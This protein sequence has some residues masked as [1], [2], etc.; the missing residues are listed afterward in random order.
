VILAAIVV[1]SAVYV[2]RLG[3]YAD[4]WAFAEM[5]QGS[6]DKSFAGLYAALASH[7]NLAVRPG[8]IVW[9]ILLHYL[10]PDD[11]TPA[12]V[13]NHAVFA[14]SAVLLYA[15]LR[16]LR[17]ARGAAYYVTLLYVCL[18]TYAAAKFWYANHQATLSLFFF[19]LAFV[20][21]VRLRDAPARQRVA[22][23]LAVFL[24]CAASNLCYE[25]FA[26]LLPC[27]PLFV[28]LISGA[29]WGALARDRW[30]VASTAL[31]LAAV[32]MTTAFKLSFH[33]GAA[34]PRSAGE[35]ALA[36]ARLYLHA[37]HTGLWTLGLW[38][39]RM[40][41]GI[42]FSSYTEA[43]AIAA[44]AGALGLLALREI[45]AGRAASRDAR[46][47][48]VAG[49]LAYALAGVVAWG[50]GYVAYLPNF[51]YGNA[52]IGEQTRGNIA[53][54][55]GLALLGYAAF[56]LVER[57]WPIL[58]RAA[59]AAFCA[60]GLLVQAA[61]GAMWARAVGEQDKL[62]AEIEPVARSLRPGDTLLIYGACP[63]VGAGPVYPYGWD[64]AGRLHVAGVPQ[65]NADIVRRLTQLRPDGLAMTI[66]PVAQHV[67]RYRG[68]AVYDLDDG[69]LTRIDSSARAAEFFARHPLRQAV[70]CDY[71]IEIGE[72][73][74]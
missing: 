67:Y 23:A 44:A 46:A 27:L 17:P 71:R 26:F 28:W 8:Q 55:I 9:Y 68:L 11:P 43:A 50:L 20:C 24:A 13:A 51:L 56:R 25:L 12:H 69:S 73:L 33:F 2:L 61:V 45:V 18:P 40:A 30:F 15:G 4:D 64:L 59:F 3:F 37:G 47:P 74:Y 1:S 72:A 38:L 66:N 22:L 63:Y 16:H 21:V 52:P 36:A 62:F 60:M 54:T 31:A 7:P 39:P 65:V 5:L 19:A 35:F 70:R 49:P 53:A 41:A 34:M 6:R 14:V 58:A 29:G 48:R 42:L 32:A 10:S 57:R